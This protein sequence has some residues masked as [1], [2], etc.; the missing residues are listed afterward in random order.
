MFRITTNGQST[1]TFVTEE[2]RQ[3]I[4]REEFTNIAFSEVGQIAG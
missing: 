2:G 4:E 3:M 1:A